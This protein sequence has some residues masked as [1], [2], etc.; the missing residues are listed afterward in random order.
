MDIAEQIKKII[1]QVSLDTV[2]TE[3]AN[4]ESMLNDGPQ[5]ARPLRPHK[6]NISGEDY[7]A[8]DAKVLNRSRGQTGRGDMRYLCRNKTVVGVAVHR[9]NGNGYR[10]IA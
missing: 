10:K 8:C 2:S 3:I 4:V 9:S 5:Y 1:K 7:I 6:V